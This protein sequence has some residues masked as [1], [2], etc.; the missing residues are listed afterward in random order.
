MSNKV[1][2]TDLEFS[3]R[4]RSENLER[5]AQEEFDLVVVGGGITG[6]GIARDAALRGF[7]TALI[8]KN[9]F[10]SGTSSKSSRLIHGGLRYLENLEFG[11]VFE[12]SQERRILRKIAPHL[13][14]ALPFIMPVYVDNPKPYWMIRIG[15]WLYD[16]LALF[17][18]VKLHRS[19]TAKELLAMEP[20]VSPQGLQGGPRFYDCRVDD[21]RLTLATAQSAHR[22][23]A[24]L[25]NHAQVVGLLKAGGKVCG[26]QVK[27]EFTG[28]EIEVKAKVVAGAVGPWGDTLLRMDRPDN[29]PQL[30]PTKGIHIIVSRERVGNNNALS[31]IVKRDG[32]L[33]FVIPWG[34]FSIIGTTDTDYQ[35]RPEEAAVEAAD[36]EYVLEAF[37]QA[38][39]RVKL[40]QEDIISAYV[41]V[42]PLVAESAATESKVSREHRI[43]TPPSGLIAIAGGKLTTYRVMAKQVVD[44]AE[45]RLATDFGVHAKQGCVTGKLP[46]EGAAPGLH[47][48]VAEQIEAAANLL[49]LDSSI[50][51]H[52]LTAYGI[53]YTRILDLIKNDPS[54]GEPIVPGLPYLWAEVPHAIRH[55]MALT[56]CDLLIRR[57][58]IIY[59]EPRQGLDVAPEVA[60]RMGAIL[61]WSLE[62]EARQLAA[63]RREVELTRRYLDNFSICA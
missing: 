50:G 33:M 62:E 8:E 34:K 58:H 6:T 54:L 63:Y 42:R 40:S 12:A 32:R 55:E 37:N 10:A 28:K 19:L 15:V 1:A 49:G 29:P 39:P 31:Y 7:K 48:Q 2:L 22:A 30:R 25:V 56:L 18:N 41:G 20:M 23:G 5:L 24:V 26:V 53:G 14:S 45:K 44:L 17:R 43:F 52:L 61:G 36:V 11:L 16:I 4:I 35:G 13:V 46:L 60:R 3:P 47:A 38:F 57:T 27:D 51:E 59:E 21:A 9:D